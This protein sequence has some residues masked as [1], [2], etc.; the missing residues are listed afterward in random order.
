MLDNLSS[1]LLNIFCRASSGK[2]LICF[3]CDHFDSALSPYIGHFL[4]K[5]TQFGTYAYLFWILISNA[6]I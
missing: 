4:A 5:T 6:K 1:A 2:I 3:Y